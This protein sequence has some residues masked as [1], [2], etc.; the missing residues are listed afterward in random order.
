MSE[1]IVDG[2]LVKY[3]KAGHGRTVLLLHGWADNAQTFEYLIKQ[4]ESS[5]SV[6]AVDLPG[7]GNSQAPEAAWDLT[8]YAAWLESF[9]NKLD[10]DPYAV[11]GHSNGGALAI[12]AT[13]MNKLNPEKLVLLAASGIRNSGS[14]RKFSIKVIAKTG[15]ALTF[16]LPVTIRRRLQQYLYGTVGSD[17]L[18]SAHMKETFKKTVKQDIQDDAAKLKVKTLLIYGDNDKATPA[19]EI[20]QRFNELIKDSQ[21]QIITDAGH[22][23]HHDEADSVSNIIKEFIK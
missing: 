12:H 13:A 19:H 7:F 9:N 10:I 5:Y 17:M 15:K 4:L 22:F 21:F 8:D 2:L 20:G 11:V 14:I 6:I 18:V 23:V 16:W 1:I 3:I